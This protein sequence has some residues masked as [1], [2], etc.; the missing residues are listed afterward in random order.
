MPSMPKYLRSASIGRLDFFDGGVN[1]RKLESAFHAGY[2]DGRVNGWSRVWK[3]PTFPYRLW[4]PN[5]HAMDHLRLTYAVGMFM[6]QS[7][8]SRSDVGPAD[9]SW[10]QRICDVSR[11]LL[12]CGEGPC[13]GQFS[14]EGA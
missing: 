1:D 3:M 5:I 14:E 6:G 11:F 13:K 10:H 12:P 2:H 7:T 4:D 9:I 8:T